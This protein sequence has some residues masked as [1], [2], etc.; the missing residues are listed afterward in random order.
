MIAR[1][2]LKAEAQALGVP[3]TKVIRDDGV[4]MQNPVDLDV[5]RDQGGGE[6][7]PELIDQSVH[8]RR[9][10]IVILVNVPYAQDQ[11]ALLELC[12][13]FPKILEPPDLP[14]GSTPC[15]RGGRLG[16][17]PERLRQA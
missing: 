3:V 17:P 7:H 10:F 12:H 16:K 14:A 5:L 1:R 6:V 11:A 2:R 8:Q 9:A 13:P 15:G 4:F